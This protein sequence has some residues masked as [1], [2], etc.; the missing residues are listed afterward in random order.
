VE[1]ESPVSVGGDAGDEKP[2]LGSTRL[3]GPKPYANALA[4][5][6]SAGEGSRVAVGTPE[7]IAA[8]PQSYTGQYLEQV[9]KRRPSSKARRAA[10]TEAA[11]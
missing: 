9:L 2:A 6:A 3:R 5:M 7:E 4:A 8:A 10:A 11:E 1:T